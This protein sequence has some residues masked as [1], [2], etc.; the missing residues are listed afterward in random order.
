MEDRINIRNEEKESSL[1]FKFK[2]IDNYVKI[3]TK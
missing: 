3:R 2:E 1:K